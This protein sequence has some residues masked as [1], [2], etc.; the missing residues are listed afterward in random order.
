MFLVTII[1][2]T[3]ER[4]ICVCKRTAGQDVITFIDPAT[5]NASVTGRGREG[6]VALA[7]AASD[8]VECR[9][10]AAQIESFEDDIDS[11]QTTV[12]AI[13][14]DYLDSTHHAAGSTDHDDRYYTEAESYDQTEIDAFFEGE[15]GGKKQV[16]I[17]RVLGKY[18]PTDG[19]VKM[20]FYVNAAPSGWTLV[21]NSVDRLLGV[22][23]DG[24]EETYDTGGTTAGSAWSAIDHAHTMP[25][26]RHDLQFGAADALQ[27]TG[28]IIGK[29][30]S[31]QSG[32]GSNELSSIVDGSEGS[33]TNRYPLQGRTESDDP[34]NTNA[35]ASMVN[36]RPKAMVGIVCTLDAYAS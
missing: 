11:L 28:S 4:E 27:F 35:N 22:R 16:S 14:A 1:K 18:F 26:H 21:A 3:G 32:G 17:N 31:D 20:W 24:G 6:T 2:S 29:V 10:T 13:N 7:F 5:G 34:G 8:R 12:T 15:A 36:F 23:D 30:Y 19:T 25:S 9:L 33:T